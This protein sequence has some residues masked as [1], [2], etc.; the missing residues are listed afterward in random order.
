MGKLLDISGNYWI[1]LDT[2]GYIWKL[3][4]KSIKTRYIKKLLNISGNYW[5]HLEITGYI[6]KILDIFG[7]CGI[8]PHI[9]GYNWT[10]QAV[11]GLWDLGRGENKGIHISGKDYIV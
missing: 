11:P 3:L 2:T 8:Y 10:G 6:W 4:D 1:Y 7:N 5:I 9:T